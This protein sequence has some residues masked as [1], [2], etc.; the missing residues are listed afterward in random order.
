MKTIVL[1]S[2]VTGV[3]LDVFLSEKMENMT[4]SAASQLIQQGLC[5]EAASGHK[6]VKLTSM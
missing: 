1:S 2:D 4:R 5:L 6:S 3:R